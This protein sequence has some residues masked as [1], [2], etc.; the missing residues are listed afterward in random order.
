VQ[1][2]LA[3]RRTERRHEYKPSGALLAGLLRCARCGGGMVPH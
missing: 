1:A 3:G 2:L